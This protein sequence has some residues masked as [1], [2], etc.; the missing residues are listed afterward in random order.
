MRG[1]KSCYWLGSSSLQRRLAARSWP[2]PRFN[3]LLDRRPAIHPTRTPGSE[4]APVCRC[5][6]WDSCLCV[7]CVLDPACSSGSWPLLP[8]VHPQAVLPVSTLLWAPDAYML[9]LSRLLIIPLLFSHLLP[10]F[11]NSA[12][13][14]ESL[15]FLSA[16]FF[17]NRALI[18]E[19][20]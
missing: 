6:G 4:R 19:R 17:R 14:A 12:A 10:S 16:I 11:Q 2:W 7:R 1:L 13:G 9:A 8:C 5:P 20:F 15:L 3:I 18:L